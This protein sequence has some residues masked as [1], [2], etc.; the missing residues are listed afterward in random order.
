MASCQPAN[1]DVFPGF[2][3]L[4][5][6]L[7]GWRKATTGNTLAFTGYMLLYFLWLFWSAMVYRN[8]HNHDCNQTV[9][10]PSQLSPDHPGVQ[11]HLYDPCAS[12]HV[13]PFWQG[14]NGRHLD[15]TV[16][17]LTW[18]FIVY[19]NQGKATPLS[20][21]QCCTALPDPAYWWPIS[22]VRLIEFLNSVF[23]L[24][25]LMLAESNLLKLKNMRRPSFELIE[26]EK[27]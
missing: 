10:L 3:F 13:P 19:Q 23:P 6:F 14:F 24:S 7:F 20:K 2:A 21:G 5:P 8:F 4:H 16:N 26:R 25:W 11:S 17:R 27:K 9:V 12:V 18:C 15:S 22:Y 1:V